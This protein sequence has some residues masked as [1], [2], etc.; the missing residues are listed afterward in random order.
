[1]G[2]DASRNYHDPGPDC[3]YCPRLAAFRE[4]NRKQF[5]AFHNAPVPA[6][7]SLDSK[8]LIVG[9]APGLKGAN[10]T[11]RPFTADFAGDLLYPTL[12][13]TR[14]ASG[15]Y[16]RRRDDGLKLVDCR[17][18]NAAR[19]VPPLNKPEPGEIKT[20]RSHFLKPEIASM[21][22]LRAILALGTVSHASVIAAFGLRQAAF[23]FRHGA[24]HDLG[25]GPVLFD[26]Y[27]CSRYNTSTGVLTPA[28]FEAVITKLAAFLKV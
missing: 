28:M 16:Q 5:P 24:R 25:E 17:V 11:G 27:H 26:S 19:C 18:T 3:A 23:K 20:C 14:F 9:L 10:A 7:G 13:K 2:P 15:H 4:A 22:N 21:P 8:L 6:F 12:L 1:M